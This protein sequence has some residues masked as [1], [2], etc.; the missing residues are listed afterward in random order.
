MAEE[1][2]SGS[3]PYAGARIT[4]VC[5]TENLSS[6]VR[7]GQAMPMAAASRSVWVAKCE[8]RRAP[9][10]DDRVELDGQGLKVSLGL[11][12]NV[13]ICERMDEL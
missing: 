12:A 11:H 10:L 3:L 9:E 2:P 13:D 8:M 7:A 4:H 6:T 1:R 5:D